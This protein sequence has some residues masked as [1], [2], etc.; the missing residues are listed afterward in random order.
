MGIKSED[1]TLWRFGVGQIRQIGFEQSFFAETIGAAIETRSAIVLDESS[2]V[3]LASILYAMAF[4]GQVSGLYALMRL[5]Q[6]LLLTR[7][8]DLR[9]DCRRVAGN[10]GRN[11]RPDVAAKRA[12]HLTAR[13]CSC[14]V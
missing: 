8:R 9:L 4:S 2:S 6:R 12:D 7:G 14:S 3:A 13:A 1:E 11:L 5:S 10:C